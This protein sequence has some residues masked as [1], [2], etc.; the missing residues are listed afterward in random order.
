MAPTYHVGRK[1]WGASRCTDT[2]T[3]LPGSQEKRWTS[4]GEDGSHQLRAGGWA[5]GTWMGGAELNASPGVILDHCVL[6]KAK[7]GGTEVHAH[8]RIPAITVILGRA[9]EA[10]TSEGRHTAALDTRPGVFIWR[11]RWVL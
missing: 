2:V 7:E 6:G 8:G 3:G 9:K 5:A 1:A 4:L 10:E 11:Y